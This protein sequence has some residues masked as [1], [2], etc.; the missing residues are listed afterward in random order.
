MELVD[1]VAHRLKLRDLRLLDAVVRS[2]SMAKAA[3]ELNISQPAVSKAIAELERVLGVRLVDRS[4]QGV[5]PTEYGRALLDC[6]VAVFDDL[7]QG[8]KKIEF[9]ADPTAGEVRIGCPP[10]IA[11]SFVTAAVDRVSQRYPRIVFHLLISEV[12]AL[13]D[14]LSERN[15]DLLITRRWGPIADERLDFEFLFDESFVVVAG[16]HN[17]WAR[18][19]RIALA[20]LVNASWVLPP[21]PESGFGAAVMEAFRSCGLGYP[22][23]AVIALPQEVRVSLL[24]TGHF[25][26]IFPV[27]ILRFPTKRTG[28]KILPVELPMAPVPNGIVTLKNR[29]LSPVARLFIEQARDLAKPVAKRK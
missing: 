28:I 12:S 15:V 4:R 9:L 14:E 8:I 1:R 21:P 5:E 7:R 23:T 29:M 11:P 19:R 2:R 6:G 20:E 10:F 3:I 13:H 18:R 27:S 24:A 25:L 22:R 16:A 26:T 17:P